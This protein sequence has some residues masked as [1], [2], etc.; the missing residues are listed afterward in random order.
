M[1]FFFASELPHNNFRFIVRE[2]LGEFEFARIGGEGFGVNLWD[3]T[4]EEVQRRMQ[5]LLTTVREA[6]AAHPVMISV[7]VGRL[8]AGDSLNQALIKADQALY[9][10]KHNGRNR[11]TYAP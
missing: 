6:P 11:F 2:A 3:I 8:D 1:V 7:G 10:S 4:H 9:D 5:V